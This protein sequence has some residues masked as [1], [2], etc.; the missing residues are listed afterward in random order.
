MFVPVV[1]TIR[2]VGA[3]DAPANGPGS[4]VIEIAGATAKRPPGR[5]PHAV[6]VA[7]RWH[8]ME[9]ASLAFL[10]AVR[11]S[12]RQIRAAIGV[13]MIDPRLLTAAEYIQYEGYLR[14]EET[15]AAVL[16]LAKRGGADQ[17]NR[18]P[19]WAQ[20]QARPP[21]RPGVV[22]PPQRRRSSAATQEP[23]VARLPQGR[24][25]MGDA[26]PARRAGRRRKS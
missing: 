5:F 16:A 18:P 24:H 7:D 4:I 23:R 20:P 11:K 15:N 8:L 25:R 21:D 1:T 13:T 2:E 3:P 26:P 14:R 6:Q 19:P 12:M 17:G 22:R 10:D 9:N